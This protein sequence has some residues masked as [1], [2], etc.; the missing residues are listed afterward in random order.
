MNNEDST[1]SRWLGLVKG[2]VLDFHW[3]DLIQWR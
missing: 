2:H 3:L 1:Q